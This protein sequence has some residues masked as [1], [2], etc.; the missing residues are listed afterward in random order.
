MPSRKPGGTFLKPTEYNGA[1]ELFMTAHATPLRAS[2]MIIALVI[3][4]MAGQPMAAGGSNAGSAG[5]EPKTEPVRPISY[6]PQ[7]RAN[8]IN[9]ERYVVDGVCEHDGVRQM[10]R[11]LRRSD[12]EEMWA[13]LPHAGGSGECQW[14][15]IG[16]E[17]KSEADRARLRVD[18]DYLNKLMAANTEL[19]IYH[20]HPLKYFECA[21]H[22]DCSGAASPADA[23]TFDRRW[24]TDLVFS[25]PSP[26]DVHFMMDV[27]ARFHRRYQRMGTIR[28]K[29]VTPYGVVNYGLTD[30]GLAKFEEERFGRSE[31]L[32]I[33]WVAASR[34]ADDRVEEVIKEGPGSIMAAVRRLAQSLNSQYLWVSHGTLAHEGGAP[35]EE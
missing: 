21:S 30:A 25:M 2:A 13:F 18:M 29:V 6:S 4:S 23:G 24:I 15:E 8:A 20:F 22:A 14:H 10:A 11:L 17:E 16:R 33:S 1:A 19:H 26:S 34:L 31:G 3:F 9:A 7:L 28:H 32:Y 35:G 27:T 12:L 5:A